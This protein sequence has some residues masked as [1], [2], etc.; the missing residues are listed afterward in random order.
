MMALVAIAA[1]EF[2]A[3]R[4]LV[5]FESQTGELLVW[6]GLPMA[7]ILAVGLLI[8]QRRLRSRPFVIGFEVFGAIALALYFAVSCYPNNAALAAYLAPLGPLE[9]TVR[10]APLF[11]KMPFLYS[12][13]VVM[14]ALPQVACAVI[15]GLVSR[16][17]R[18]TI[19]KRTAQAPVD[20]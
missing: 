15:G 17:Y 16:K 5:E 6:G 9:R 1:L 20:A 12:A 19:T 3:I 13:A 10:S 4:A 11:I 7:N 8:G 2:W 14:L 18:I